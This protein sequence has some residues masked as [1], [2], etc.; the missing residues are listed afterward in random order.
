VDIGFFGSIIPHESA[1]GGEGST[2][3]N[4]PFCFSISAP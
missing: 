4:P 3:S 2:P 1:G